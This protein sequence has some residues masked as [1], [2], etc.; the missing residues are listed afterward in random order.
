[1]KFRVLPQAEIPVINRI[2]RAEEDTKLDDDDDTW[3]DEGD[4]IKTGDYA[5][6]DHGRV[7]KL[8]QS[9][10]GLFQAFESDGPK[11]ERIRKKEKGK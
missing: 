7:W 3:D 4:T 8:D 5:Q 2:V 6:D 10:T 11:Q 1:M 9:L